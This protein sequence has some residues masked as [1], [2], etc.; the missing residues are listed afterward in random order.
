MQA[1]INKKAHIRTLGLTQTG[2]TNNY[3]THNTIEQ[4][5]SV[6]SKCTGFTCT[7]YFWRITANKNNELGKRLLKSAKESVIIKVAP[8]SIPCLRSIAYLSAYSRQMTK[9]SKYYKK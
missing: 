4:F 9:I 7:S 2:R 3:T 5:M 8:R 6:A 1:N